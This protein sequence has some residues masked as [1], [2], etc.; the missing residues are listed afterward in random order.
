M[1]EVTSGPPTARL[2]WGCGC[3]EGKLPVQC[4]TASTLG[5][6]FGKTDGGTIVGDNLSIT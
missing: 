3:K 6:C 4:G 5:T 1:A 2:D